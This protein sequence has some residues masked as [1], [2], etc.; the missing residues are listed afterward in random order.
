MRKLPDRVWK[1]PRREDD[2]AAD[3]GMGRILALSDGVFAIAL[4]LLTLELAVPA[5]TGDNGL[6]KALLDLWP[7]YL[8]YVLS[9]LV[10]A[11][12]WVTHHVAFRLIDRYDATLVWL[13]FLLLLFVA[14]LP[15]PTAVLGEHQGTP[16]AAVLY[17][18]SVCLASA[19]GAAYWWYASGRGG[20]LR[21]DVGRAQVRAL[22]A[23]VLS[24]PVF[25]ALTLPVAGFAPYAAEILW[26]LVF[27]LNRIAYA[28]FF[29]DE[30]QQ[31]A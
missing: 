10:I 23:R 20:L 3:E 31:L 25:F 2:E 29:A 24:G 28:W 22:R 21:P 7:R 5:T 17:A 27:P 19:A 30:Q 6:P 1:V 9:F 26:V 11:R 16:A 8:A 12:F 18:A 15:F 4:T 14:F 13:N